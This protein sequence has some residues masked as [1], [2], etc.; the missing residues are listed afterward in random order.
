MGEMWKVEGHANG[1]R[2]GV[3]L[4][5]FIE[6]EEVV[7]VVLVFMVLVVV[8]GGLWKTWGHEEGDSEPSRQDAVPVDL[9]GEH[10]YHENHFQ[11]LKE[12]KL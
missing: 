5:H 2:G 7:V 3:P 1:K 9:I 12:N 11:R 8:R 10:Y 6:Q 4:S